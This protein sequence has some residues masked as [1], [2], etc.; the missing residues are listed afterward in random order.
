MRNCTL[1]ILLFVLF[2]YRPAAGQQNDIYTSYGVDDGLSQS[3][4]WSIVQDKQGFLWAGTS[5]GICRF[6]G[7]KFTVYRGGGGN[8]D[9]ITGGTYIKFYI[10]SNNE[11]WTIS[12]NGVCYYDRIKDRFT[13]AY[14]HQKYYSGDYNCFVGED[15]GYIYAGMARYG[16]VKIDK[17][18]H[19]TT[20]I[21]NNA[22]SGISSWLNAALNKGDI[23]VLGSDE[24]CL[25]YHMK[26][27]SLEKMPFS[28]V[29][30]VCNLNDSTLI[31]ASYN[32]I[33][34]LNKT[35]NSYK[36]IPMKF[37]NRVNE[38]ITGL[39]PLSTTVIL[40]VSQS[41]IFYVDAVNWKVTRHVQSFAKDEQNTFSYVQCVY[42]DR[43]GNIWLGTNGDGLRK[44][45]APNKNF[46]YYPS[47]NP[48]S[49]LVRAMYADRQHLYIGY[50]AVGM[51]V[52]NRDSGFV[53]SE[54]VNAVPHSS[55]SVFGIT[56]LDNDNLL[57]RVD[58]RQ[59]I[60]CYS[61][62]NKKQ[63]DLSAAFVD[64]LKDPQT[65]SRHPFFL[66]GGNLIYTNVGEHAICS[67]DA[68][69]GTEISPRVVVDIRGEIINCGY[70]DNRGT[71][72]FGTMNCLYYMEGN[73]TQKF[74]LPELVHVKSINQDRDGRMWIG[75]VK[76][77]YIIDSNKN[78]VQHYSESNKLSSQFIY[79]ILRDDAGNIWFSH[80]KGLSVYRTASGTFRHYT[81]D[82]GLQSNEFNT[83]A[84][85]KAADGEL[86]FGG[87]AGT[88][89]F[90]PQEVSDNPHAPV[91]VITNIKLF[92]SPLK[93]DSAYWNIRSLRF[94]Y[95]Q[96]SLSFEFA[97]LEYTN[98]KNNQY[99]YMMEGV[100]KDW[101][102]VGDERF[103]RYSA[104]PPGNY[105][106]KV[107]AA[108]N[109]GLWQQQP[110]TISISIVPP[111][112]QQWWFRILGGLLVILCLSGI[113]I[114]I[115][116]IRHRREIRA[117]ELRQK[118]QLERERISRDL[119]DTVGTQLSLISN[120]IEWVAHPLKE[121]SDNE[122]AE[123]LQFVND[124]AR[125]IIGT[126][127]ETIWAFNKQQITLKEF[128]DKLKAFVQKQ[129]SIYPEIILNFNEQIDQNVVLGPSEALDL[130]R[131]CQEAIANA[132]K[133]AN[134]RVI[135]ITIANVDGKYKLAIDDDGKGFDIN[136]VDPAVQ[137]GLENMKFRAQ[138]VGSILVIRSEQ[139]KGTHITIAKK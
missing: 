93:T 46:K 69:S 124:T 67:F 16:I 63:K 6:D 84:Y 47:H 97:A 1:L 62:K 104:L 131:I 44:L 45:T 116:R 20:S 72:W 95:L 15:H 78:L 24:G 123:K 41:G 79:G 105:V 136:S 51:S 28:D 23:W 17:Q 27:A 36:R 61:K 114:W 57:M 7:Y 14:S 43:S 121:I 22:V 8:S 55:N 82:D 60:L 130:F 12:Q 91:T 21:T 35:N 139:G 110:T 76:G 5:D 135:D 49:S 125:D 85:F 75:S 96:N 109:D 19:E 89:S 80:N 10:D 38:N 127:R 9:I 102:N 37:G 50:Y 86:F 106:F 103:A 74:P 92:D 65:F 26:S 99:A 40:L 30:V 56:A 52:Y 33:V 66:K 59:S 73:K 13:K 132:L 32:E 3:S 87:I 129:L 107:K 126:L 122:K 2:C 118:I 101:I 29:T 64:L 68:S 117:L 120:N 119:H 71:L 58:A 115:Q 112:W 108:N 98:P 25:V 137:N 113:I 53:R 77:I 111:F 90:Y 31:F 34:L 54:V 81:K 133:Y 100:D 88:N 128:S 94:S 83:G 18:T 39:L 4:V 138:D 134:A 11:L 42:R 70:I 48:K